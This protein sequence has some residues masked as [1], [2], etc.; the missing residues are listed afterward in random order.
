[1]KGKNQRFFDSVPVSK[2]TGTALRMTRFGF[3]KH[4]LG[5]FQATPGVIC[6]IASL[7]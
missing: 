5:I 4:A 7:F 6:G 3:Y 1:M 2:Q